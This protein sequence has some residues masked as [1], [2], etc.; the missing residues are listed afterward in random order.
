L[1]FALCFIGALILSGIWVLILVTQQ[2]K[3][4]AIIIPE[5]ETLHDIANGE[6]TGAEEIV[7]I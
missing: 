2:R 1:P 7:K 5:A 6:C 4:N 3:T